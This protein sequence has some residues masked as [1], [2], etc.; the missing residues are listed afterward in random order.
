VQ[1][2]RLYGDHSAVHRPP[3][4]YTSFIPLQELS[5]TIRDL[6]CCT[7]IAD[8]LPCTF[9][10]GTASSSCHIAFAFFNSCYIMVFKHPRSQPV[11]QVGDCIAGACHLLPVHNSLFFR[12]EERR[13]HQDT[14]SY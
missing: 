8:T 13:E 4:I 10:Q 12:E 9:R 6:P 11:K 3:A 7:G 1:S 2:R 5:V 14:A